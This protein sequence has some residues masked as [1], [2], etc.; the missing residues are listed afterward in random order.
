M[1]RGNSVPNP[2][3]SNEELFQ[4]RKRALQLEVKNKNDS[5]VLTPVA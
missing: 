4:E 1:L 5:P 3:I 2:H